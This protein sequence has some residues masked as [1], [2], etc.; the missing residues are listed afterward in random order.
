MQEGFAKT[1]EIMTAD[2]YSILFVMVTNDR[3]ESDLVWVLAFARF[4]FFDILI[5]FS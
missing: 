4:Y 2:R 1:R 3:L 5:I